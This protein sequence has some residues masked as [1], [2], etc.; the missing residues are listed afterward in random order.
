[1]NALTS[2]TTP[3]TWTRS[4][5]EFSAR[6][7]TITIAEA[8]NYCR[9]HP[10]ANIDLDRFLGIFTTD[11]HRIVDAR[12]IGLVG[13]IMDRL[14]SLKAP[15]PFEWIGAEIDKIDAV[16][17]PIAI[18]R[19]RRTARDLGIPAVDVSLNGHWPHGRRLP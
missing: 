8:F 10:V 16:T 2:P 18:E 15:K 19:L 4:L 9:A 7:P 5:P 12:D 1:M 11:A 6:S 3:S 13:I 17:F 14:T